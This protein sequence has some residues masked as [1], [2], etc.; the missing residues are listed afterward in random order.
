MNDLQKNGAS[1]GVLPTAN[2]RK[3]RRR[4]SMIWIVPLVAVISAGILVYDRIHEWGPQI[5]IR[6]KDASGVRTGQTQVKYR[7]I[8]IGDVSAIELSRDQRH[9]IV[10]VRLQRS[11]L[12]NRR[13][14]ADVRCHG[15][16]EDPEIRERMWQALMAQDGLGAQWGT[17]GVGIMRA[18]NRMNYGWRLNAAQIEAPTLILLG[19]FDNY[20]R[21]REAWQGLRIDHKVFVKVA[22]ASHF[23]QYER[24]RHVLHR[25]TREWLQSGSVDG[26]RQAELHADYD[27]RL[28]PLI[29]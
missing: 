15:Q 21:R 8:P 7:G 19:E 10:K 9:A 5:T 25:A 20:E 12:M 28:H 2:V 29:G 23:L 1:G 11:V 3:N 13:W 22:C 16:L 26:L 4:F 18:P 6:F 27:G 14:Q 17:E 24:G